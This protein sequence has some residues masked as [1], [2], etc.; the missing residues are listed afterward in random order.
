[1][2]RWYDEVLGAPYELTLGKIIGGSGK[3]PPAAAADAGAE[4]ASGSL[5]SDSGGG[6]ASAPP[7][8]F[9]CSELVAHAYQALGVLPPER[10]AAGFWPV[11]F[12]EAPRKELPLL[13]DARLGDEIPIEFTTPAVALRR[14]AE[15]RYLG[16]CGWMFLHSVCYM[17]AGGALPAPGCLW[18]PG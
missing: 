18:C 12:G 17:R 6:A 13:L 5:S 11:D 1:M 7:L 10:P 4:A 8:G 15:P 16:P 14:C 9:F 2:Q 3:R